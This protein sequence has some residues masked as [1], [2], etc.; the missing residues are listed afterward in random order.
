MNSTEQ[1]RQILSRHLPI[2]S[3]DYCIEIWEKKPFHFT[4]TRARKTKLG[5]FRYRKD[6]S[7]QTITIN[8]DLNPYQFLLTY[9]HEVAHLH[10]FLA[11][12]MKIPPHGSEWKKTFQFLISPLLRAEIFPKNILI[13]LSLHMKNPMASSA[14]DLFLMK[15]MSKY[16]KTSEDCPQVFL[17]DLKPGIQFELSGRIFKKGETRRTRVLCE[18]VKTGRKYLIAQLAKIKPLD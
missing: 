9:I 3:I 7:I 4:V 15:E 16:D 2:S 14:R 8:G 12:G 18:E 1:L 11:Y 6:R 5:D 17:S 10:A 13:P